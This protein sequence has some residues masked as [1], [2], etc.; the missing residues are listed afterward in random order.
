VRWQLAEDLSGFGPLRNM[1]DPTLHGD[2]GKMS[3]P[4]FVCQTPGGDAGGV[5]SNSGILNHAY[6]LMVDGGTYNG[7]TVTGIGLTKAGKVAYRALDNYLVSASGFL[8]AYHA[9]R[10]A[11]NDLV[12]TAGITLNDCGQVQT[13]MDAVE[14]SNPWPCPGASPQ[15]PALCPPGQVAANLFFDDLQAGG[16]NWGVESATVFGPNAWFLGNFFGTSETLHLF[17]PDQDVTT[18]SRLVNVTPIVLPAGARLQFNHAY[19]FENDSDGFYDGAVLEYR[20]ET[21]PGPWL[22]AGPLFAAG[23][24]YDGTLSSSFGNPLGGRQAFAGHSFGYTGSQYDL[25]SLAGQNT[26]FAFRLGT[27]SSVGD[28]GWFLDDIRIYTCGPSDLIFAD[29]FDAGA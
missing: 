23:T 29:G 9:F 27:D 13:A 11:C 19:G 14:L 2:P 7:R 1:M 4:Q 28:Y 24:N 25:S 21:G 20:N 17:A 10:Q 8:D 3:D 5:H 26:R 6:A 16:S 12:G 18:H 15:A 22:D